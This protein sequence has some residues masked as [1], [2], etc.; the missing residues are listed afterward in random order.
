LKAIQTIEKLKK[1]F[2]VPSAEG[3]TGAGRKEWRLWN[4]IYEVKRSEQK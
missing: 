2:R 3:G 4:E 1:G